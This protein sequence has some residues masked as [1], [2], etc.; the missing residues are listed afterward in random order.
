MSMDDLHASF[1][2]SQS[3]A[4][5]SS[6]ELSAEKY[7]PL[8]EGFDM[9]E[10]QKHELLGCLFSIVRGFVELGFSG[11]ICGQIFGE[12]VSAS[13]LPPASVESLSGNDQQ[14]GSV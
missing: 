9:S 11:D 12:S 2:E 1:E 3:I 4:P 10:A 5:A 6:L 13:S 8:V 7:L 14:G